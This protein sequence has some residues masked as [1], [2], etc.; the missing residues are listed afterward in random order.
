MK[1][2][3]FD[4]GLAFAVLLAAGL[5]IV[6]AWIAYI[7]QRT[8]SPYYHGPIWPLYALG[9]PGISAAW[10]GVWAWQERRWRVASLGFFFSSATPVGYLVEV[11][12][13]VAIALLFVSLFRAWRDRPHRR[14][15]RT[16]TLR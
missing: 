2:S 16:A 3:G 9:V 14:S 12:G 11:S 4:L 8:P 13:P 6:F 1:R 10:L 15:R 5:T 7:E